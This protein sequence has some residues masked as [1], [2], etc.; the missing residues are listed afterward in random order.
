MQLQPL[1][2]AC[3]K[4]TVGDEAHSA[5]IPPNT[6]KFMKSNFFFYTETVETQNIAFTDSSRT[7]NKSIH[8]TGTCSHTYPGTS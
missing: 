1:I 7:K 4:L 3:M 8:C 5:G 2:F 6:E